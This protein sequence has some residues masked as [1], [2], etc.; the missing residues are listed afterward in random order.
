MTT[1]PDK[2][3][4]CVCV[5]HLRKTLL[6]GDTPRDVLRDVS[7]RVGPGQSLAIMGPSGSGKSTLLNIIGSLSQPTSGRVTVFGMDPAAFT[8]SQAARFR[9]ETIGFVFQSHHLLPQCSIFENVL[10]PTLA[11][12][13][14]KWTEPPEDRARRLLERTGLT[15]RMHA[16]PGQLSGGECQRAAVVRALINSPR[17][18]L[19]DEPTGN[20]DQHSADTIGALLGELKQEERI[21]LIVVT[22]SQELASRMDAARHLREGVLL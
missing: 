9:G 4:D 14:K 15:A 1:E 10:L 7:L 21:A 3:T 11:V 12:K 13:N 17:V 19:A 8:E 6:N 16:R 20:L 22:H 2:N 18:V 5:E